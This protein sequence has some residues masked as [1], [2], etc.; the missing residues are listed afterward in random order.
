MFQ[1]R[2]FF[3]VTTAFIFEFGLDNESCYINVCVIH[4]SQGKLQHQSQK[5]RGNQGTF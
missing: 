3:A 5:V 4:F 1:K 2:I